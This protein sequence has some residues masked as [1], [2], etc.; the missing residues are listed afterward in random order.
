M[1]GSG[2][3]GE[4]SEGG[5]GEQGEGGDDQGPAAGGEPNAG[6]AGG[7]DT[8]GDDS[9]EA[10]FQTQCAACHGDAGQGIEGLGPDIAHPVDD[11]STWVVRN[12]R[13][14]GE[15]YPTGMM[16]FDESVLSTEMLEGILA[17]LAD[18]PQPTSG[19][20]LYSDYCAAC[21]GAD[22]NG[23]PTGRAIKNE[24]GEVSRLVRSGHDLGNFEVRREF[25]PQWSADELS[26]AELQLISEYIQGL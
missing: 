14:G 9:P 25:M 19:E 3:Q 24:V 21:H 13:E 7:A 6:G 17:F 16:V 11:Y 5:R 2:E 20:G 4:G 26:D 8:G 15:L 10:F 23:G 18:Q 22:A 12:G 1:G